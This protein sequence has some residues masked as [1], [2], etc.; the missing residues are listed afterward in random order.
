MSCSDTGDIAI[1]PLPYARCGSRQSPV[2]MR[3][4]VTAM[5][6]MSSGDNTYILAGDATGALSIWDTE[7]AP[8][9]PFVGSC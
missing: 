9:T 8:C 2:I 5:L 6:T 3:G 4:P 7:Y 1:H